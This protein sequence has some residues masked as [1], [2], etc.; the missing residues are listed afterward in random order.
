MLV[1]FIFHCS[2]QITLFSVLQRVLKLF[3]RGLLRN[4]KTIVSRG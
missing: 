3:E 1:D 2:K 4:A